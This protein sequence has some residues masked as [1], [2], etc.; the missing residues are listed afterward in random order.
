MGNSLKM[1]SSVV[2]SVTGELVRSLPNLNDRKKAA[3]FGL[4]V[5]DATAMPVH[6]M[7]NLHQLQRDYGEIKG[8]IPPKDKFDGSILNLSNTGGGGR[9]SDQ[10][11][12]VG[13]VILH[14][15]KKYWLKGGNYHYHLGLHAGE[16]TLEAQLTRL[17]TRTITKTGTFSSE[18]FLQ[19]YVEFM[20]TPG[21]HNDT[22]ASTAHRMFFANLVRGLPPTQC[23]DNDGHNV[24]AI[25]ALTLTIPVILKYAE[26]SAEERNAKVKEIIRCTRKTRALDSYA[27]AYSD[28][29]VSVLNGEDLRTAVEKC[30]SRLGDSDGLVRSVRT[31]VERARGD[32]MVACYIDSSFPALLFFAYKY[33]ESP[34]AAVLANANA[35]GE[36]VARGS[37]LGALVGAAHGLEAFPAWSHGL[38]AKDE[39]MAEIDA[40]VGSI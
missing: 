18:D 7:Y 22:Y 8:Y 10:G 35:G 36:N 1:S 24:D 37:L 33:A 40:F 30:G 25:D 31:M 11:E 28:M 16:N 14:G 34:E 20:Q 15:K 23:A 3:L 29:L 6:W 13:S 9:G 21:S 2:S 5:A 26:S 19:H 17:L 12:I 32:P 27:V 4:Y 38:Y 39:I